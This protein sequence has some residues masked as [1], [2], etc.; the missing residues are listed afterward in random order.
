MAYWKTRSACKQGRKTKLGV[1]KSE[2]GLLLRL[3]V[4]SLVTAATSP[5][6]TKEAS[7]LVVVTLGGYIAGS[8]PEQ[9]PSSPRMGKIDRTKLEINIGEQKL[10]QHGKKTCIQI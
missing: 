6:A 1:K 2:A 4:G 9:R 8:P 10:A 5:V 7:R 3:Q